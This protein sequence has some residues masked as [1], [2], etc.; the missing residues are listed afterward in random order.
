MKKF[1]IVIVIAA[2]AVVFLNDVGIFVNTRRN[3]I[4]ATREAAETAAGV[5]GTRDDAARVA[6]DRAAERGI[7]VYLYDQDETQV[8]VWTKVDLDGTWVYGLLSAL[9]EGRAQGESPVLMH[10]ETHPR[11]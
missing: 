11:R 9:V 2:V 5:G 8:E 7:T 1:L 10:Y 4:E 3:L 6:A